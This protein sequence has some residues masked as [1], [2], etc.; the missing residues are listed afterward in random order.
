MHDAE[1]E[2]GQLVLRLPIK[3]TESLLHTLSEALDRDK[4]E[5]TSYLYNMVADIGVDP[6]RHATW[7]E[8]E[9][10][11]EDERQLRARREQLSIQEAQEDP[12][13]GFDFGLYR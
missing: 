9:A 11:A 2:D 5:I 10:E 13:D 8:E 4:L 1:I 7:S 3:L 6:V 12:A